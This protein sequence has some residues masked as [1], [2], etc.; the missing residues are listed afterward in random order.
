MT[1]TFSDELR[2]A[3]EEGGDVPVHLVDTATNVGYVIMRADQ[4]ARVKA[5]F[6]ADDHDV[7][8]IEA[9]PFVEEVMKND[10]ANDP[11]LESYQSY[12]KQE[13]S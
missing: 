7:D 8:P 5:V 3:L 1:T 11:S 4:Y 13:R 9:Y 2:K 12:S 10:D 6:E